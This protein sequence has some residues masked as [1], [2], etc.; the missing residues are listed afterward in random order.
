MEFKKKQA[1]KKVLTLLTITIVLGLLFVMAIPLIIDVNNPTDNTQTENSSVEFNFNITELNLKEIKFHWNGTNFTMYEDSLLFFMNFDNRSSLGENNTRAVDI[2]RNSNNGTFINGAIPNMTGGKYNGSAQFTKS[3]NYINLG[4]PPI[5]QNITEN[6][7]I[8]AWVRFNELGDQ[9]SIISNGWDSVVNQ[10]GYELLKTSGNSARFKY[11]TNVTGSN[12]SRI[13]SSSDTLEA[14]TWYH[15]TGRKNNTHIS[16]FINAQQDNQLAIGTPSHNNTIQP[17][18]R[19]LH[20][21]I[22][23]GSATFFEMNGSVDNLM[24]FN[25]SLSNEEIK[26]QY[27]YAITKFD[28]QD[29]TFFTNQT[30]LTTANA[31][32]SYPYFSCATD[33]SNNE[34]CTSLRTLVKI[35]ISQNI[36]AN[37]TSSIGDIRDFFY[38]TNTHGRYLTNQSYVDTTN[39]GAFDTPSNQTF[40]RE[41]IEEANINIVRGDAYLFNT[42]SA[43]DTFRTTEGHR[44]NNVNMIKETVKY[45]AERGGMTYIILDQTPSFAQDKSSIYC[46]SSDSHTSCPYGNF[47]ILNQTYL[48]YL[49][50]VTWDGLYNSSVMVAI[51]NEPYASSWLDNLSTDNIIKGIEYAKLFNWSYISINAVYPNMKVCGPSGF[52]DFPNMTTA[53]ISNASLYNY[54]TDCVEIHPYADNGNSYLLSNQ[55]YQDVLNL[56]ANCTAL[57]EFCPYIVAGEWGDIEADLK[58]NLSRQNEWGISTARAYMGIL[59]NLPQNVTLLQYQ[60]TEMF[61]YANTFWYPEYPQKWS[62]LSEPNL[63]NEI[64]TIY[65]VTKSFATY[66]SAGSTIYNSTSTDSLLKTVSSKN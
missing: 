62:M 59:N 5:L 14:N 8:M 7:T 47:S 31:S 28:N 41:K 19:E 13:V 53:F 24:I 10:G 66:H 3:N 16:I 58:T 18:I 40:H 25:R 9:E 12:T 2:S 27:E 39:N 49:N 1:Q 45:Q 37:F 17:S 44:F 11:F 36:T 54:P 35:P 33:S 61:K 65:N 4:N 46:T 55:L 6:I 32:T 64:Y 22:M 50:E 30:N 57:G 63:D 26:K 38:G 15:L 56:Q 29:W 43:V 34:N 42:M 60:W 20:I 51:R 21:G 52:R 23:G 48:N